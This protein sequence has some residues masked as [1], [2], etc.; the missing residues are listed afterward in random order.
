M[1]NLD[2]PFELVCRDMGPWRKE[3]GLTASETRG[4]WHRLLLGISL[5]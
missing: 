5:S 1:L 2:L 3:Q 4:F